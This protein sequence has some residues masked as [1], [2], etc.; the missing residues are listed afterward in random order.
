MKTKNV[1]DFIRTQ[2]IYRYGVPRYIITNNGEPFLKILMTNL[3]EKFKFAQHKSSMY[4][5]PVNGL[6]E[7]F[8]KTLCNLLKK[9]VTK[10]QGDWSV[11]YT[12]LTLPTNRE[13]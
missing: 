2:I 9:V 4:N 3:Y 11:S 8:N 5:A 13:V 6:A 7:A 10:S 1:I 12:H